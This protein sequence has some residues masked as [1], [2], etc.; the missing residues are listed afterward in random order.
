MELAGSIALVTGGSRGIG[1]NVVQSVAGRGTDVIFTYQSN[2]VAAD[3][4]VNEV[5][6]MGRRA[7]ALQL[8][9]GDV[10]TFDAFAGQVRDI[11][12]EWGTD[13]FQY[14]VNNAG[15]GAY[16][17]IADT[18]EAQFDEVMSVDVKGP[19]F[20]TQRLLPLISNGGRVV[21]VTTALTRGGVTHPGQATY[22]MAK[23]TVEV[24]TRYLSQEL[25][26]RGIT[27]N[28]VAP[29]GIATDFMGGAMRDPDM[30][31]M[32]ASITALGRV[33]QVEDVGGV[34]ASLLSPEMG[35]VN[36]QRIEV[37]GGQ[38]L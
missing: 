21:N 10:G 32:A 4:L 20:L 26:P 8:D 24:F 11:L 17:T 7:V 13:R 36:A 33:G 5:E 22:A 23:G 38:N 30:Q 12:G 27:V 35:W 37:S 25:G 31:E 19:F 28:V 34:V 6:G 1:R 14:L 2:K 9:V 29:G 3:A 16:A 18:T 15:I